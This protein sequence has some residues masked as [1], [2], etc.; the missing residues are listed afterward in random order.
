MKHLII[1]AAAMLCLASCKDNISIDSL[2]GEPKIVAYCMPTASDTTYIHLSA[3]VPVKGYS[4]AVKLQA[5][6]QASVTY[7]INGRQQTVEPMGRGYFRV[8]AHQ[9]VG[10]QIDLKAEAPGLDPVSATVAIPDTV[11]VKLVGM[12]RVAVYDEVNERRNT[13]VQLAA[14]FT[15]PAETHDYYAVRVSRKT[16]TGSMKA[17]KDGIIVRFIDYVDYLK[18]TDE[19]KAPYDSITADYMQ[20]QGPIYMHINTQSEPLFTTV[21]TTDDSF[22]FSDNYF[23]DLNIFDD[24]SINGKTYTL[25]LNVDDDYYYDAYTLCFFQVELLRLSPEYYRFLSAL[26]DIDNNELARSGLSLIR[27]MVSNVSGGLG[28]MGAWNTGH[29]PWTEWKKKSHN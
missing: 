24:A 10:D 12:Q 4:D 17:Y 20:Q 21:T 23:G 1:L 6:D 2:S 25:R 29:S 11:G 13:Y 5:L 26:N 27:P 22:G 28:L 19:E 9:Q 15:D 18:M 8:V 3:S 14:T 16:L 7:A